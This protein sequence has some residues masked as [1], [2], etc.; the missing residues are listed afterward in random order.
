MPCAYPSAQT[1]SIQTFGHVRRRA[2][3][4]VGVHI[5]GGLVRSWTVD[6]KWEEKERDDS[7]D[8]V[9]QFVERSEEEDRRRNSDVSAR[10]DCFWAQ[11][12]I[13][14][15]QVVAKRKRWRGIRKQRDDILG[16]GIE[17]SSILQ[18]LG[19]SKH[20]KT[21][22]EEGGHTL[23]KPAKSRQQ[24]LNFLRREKTYSRI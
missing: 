8:I 20:Y 4:A 17:I 23:S 16:D 11:F 6:L 3:H 13:C 24:L 1:H 22:P 10:I 15:Q 18:I 12:C 21:S 14:D 19:R 9:A 5:F 2:Q 7:C